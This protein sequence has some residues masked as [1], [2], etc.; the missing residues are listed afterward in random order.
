MHW[1]PVLLAAAG[2]GLVAA[3]GDG[4]WA[5]PKLLGARKFMAELM[6]ESGLGFG[7]P[8][9]VVGAHARERREHQH[10]H[11]KR[12]EGGRD[13]QCGAGFGSCARGY[14]CSVEGYVAYGDTTAREERWGGG[15]REQRLTGDAVGVASIP[16]TAR[17]PIAR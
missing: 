2:A 7:S 3:H 4:E 14:C 16:T 13:G 11:D 1:S 10:I 9:A 17:R 12:Q 6:A 15:E 5:A 8:A